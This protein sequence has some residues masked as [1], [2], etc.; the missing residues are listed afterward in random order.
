M[1]EVAQDADQMTYMLHT[2]SEFGRTTSN[3]EKAG[4]HWTLI[5]TKV[6]QYNKG[7]NSNKVKQTASKIKSLIMHKLFWTKNLN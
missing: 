4:P 6:A 2:Q 7:R 5:N 1:Q 3:T